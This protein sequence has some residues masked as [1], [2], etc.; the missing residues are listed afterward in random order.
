MST[1]H[2]GRLSAARRAELRTMALELGDSGHTVSQIAWNLRTSPSTARRLLT[3]ATRAQDS[4][5][6]GRGDERTAG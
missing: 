4:T 6:P 1:E 3:E 5:A 2:N